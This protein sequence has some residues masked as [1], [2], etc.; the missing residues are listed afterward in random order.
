MV[1]TRSSGNDASSADDAATSGGGATSGANDAA[2]SG[3]GATSGASNDAA[4]SGG[5]ATSG[6]DNEAA[7]SGG[8]AASTVAG[9]NNV[10]TRAIAA[11]SAFQDLELDNDSDSEYKACNKLIQKGTDKLSDP[12]NYAAWVPRILMLLATVCMRGWFIAQGHLTLTTKPDISNP[13]KSVTV[14]AGGDGGVELRKHQSMYKKANIWLYRILVTY[15]KGPK[16][17]S[18]INQSLPNDGRGLWKNLKERCERGGSVRK[19]ELVSKFYSAKMLD[20]QKIQAWI[21]YLG[22]LRVDLADQFGFDIPDADINGRA[23]HAIKAMYRPARDALTVVADTIAWEDFR[24]RLVRACQVI[25]MD[26]ARDAEAD[27]HAYAATIDGKAKSQKER[28]RE[29]E[30]KIAKLRRENASTEE[31]ATDTEETTDAAE[32]PSDS[33]PVDA[34]MAFT[35]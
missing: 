21:D 1:R 20:T 28:I 31:T 14:S 8:G 12:K 9:A 29:L 25:D 4:T 27:L 18:I 35:F 6:A 16:M 26:A 24:V 10:E 2:T 3:D 15:L 17:R 7:T 22:Q 23:L 11:A 5:G 33:K 34:R 32:E 13:G 19:R 30:A